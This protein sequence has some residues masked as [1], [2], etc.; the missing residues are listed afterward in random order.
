MRKIGHSAAHQPAQHTDTEDI[1]MKQQTAFALAGGMTAFLLVAGSAVVTSWRA[2]AATAQDA[3]QAAAKTASTTTVQA[4]APAATPLAE[5]ITAPQPQVTVAPT[6]DASAALQAAFATREA[7][8][9]QRISEAN[10]LLEQSNADKQALAERVATGNVVYVKPAAVRY[11]VSL[12]KAQ[13]L[14]LTAAKPVNAE[15][16][17]KR[18]ELVK[19]KG[20]VAYEV[21]LSKGIV[22]VDARTGVVLLNSLAPAAVP[23]AASNR[24]TVYTAA[25]VAPGNSNPPAPQPAAP[26]PQPQQPQPQPQPTHAPS[27]DDTSGDD[28]DG[29]D[30]ED[31]HGD[32]HEDDHSNDHDGDDD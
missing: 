8:Y 17:V 5:A 16:R 23:A 30:H 26:Q 2:N 19:F 7:A 24:F 13:Q 12:R 29:D 20:V 32:A 9:Q 6:A 27:S 14:A 25:S 22:Y 18:T 3:A 21:S 10:A 31:D 4:P 28:Q 11:P 15:S 1:N